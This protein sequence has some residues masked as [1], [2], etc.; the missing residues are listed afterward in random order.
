MHK[1]VPR[2]ALAGVRTSA[3]SQ[4]R[5]AWENLCR[6]G[7]SVEVRGVGI[8][9]A[10]TAPSPRAS[11]LRLEAR[12]SARSCSLARAEHSLHAPRDFGYRVAVQISQTGACGMF[13]RLVGVGVGS[14]DV[15]DLRSAGPAFPPR[16][17]ARDPHA[18]MIPFCFGEAKVHRSGEH[19]VHSDQGF[20]KNRAGTEATG[21]G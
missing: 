16:A 2:T 20:L 17:A 14:K 5:I 12:R 6:L 4:S 18:N 9:A 13:G 3:S 7:S 19:L 11:N 15:R 8:S 1:L 21:A 10:L